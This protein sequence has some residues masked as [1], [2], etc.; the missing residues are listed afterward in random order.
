MTPQQVSLLD[1]RGALRPLSGALLLHTEGSAEEHYR[2]NLYM[3]G[4]SQKKA[5][6]PRA[7]GSPLREVGSEK[8]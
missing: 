8:C 2:A 1:L 4:L 5:M 7:P 3:A 6:R